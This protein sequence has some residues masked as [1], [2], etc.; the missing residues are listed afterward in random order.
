MKI[1]QVKAI[2]EKALADPAVGDVDFI[3]NTEVD[4]HFCLEFGREVDVIQVPLDDDLTKLT[5]VVAVLNFDMGD[6]EEEDV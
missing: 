5:T 2:L 4:G 6:M 1:S 3:V